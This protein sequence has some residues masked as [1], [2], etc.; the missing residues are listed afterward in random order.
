MYM[1]KNYIYIYMLSAKLASTVCTQ[2]FIRTKMMAVISKVECH[3]PNK[4]ASIRL[5]YILTLYV[6][7]LYMYMYMYVCMF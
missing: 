4:I 5:V 3:V 1:Y 7:T 6:Y 2:I